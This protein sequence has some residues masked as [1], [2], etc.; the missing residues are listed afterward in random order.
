[1]PAASLTN[2]DSDFGSTPTLF[3]ATING[4][5]RSMLGVSNKNGL[6]YAFDRTNLSAG[7]LWSVQ[8]AASGESPDGG[9]GTISP[10]AWDGTSLYVAGTKTTINGST[11]TGSVSALDPAT[12]NF[13][14]QDCLNTG[15]VLGAVM[16]SPTLVTVATN[17]TMYVLAAS[18]GAV[19]FQYTDPS[20]S[21][22]FWGP[23]TVANGMVFAGNA[24][25]TL[26]AFHLP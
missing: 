10:S 16:A 3:T 1:V 8:I 6:Y 26:Y 2:A 19:L 22:F 24:D 21:T 15:A 5:T 17:K 7:P 20:S 25:G 18:S 14:W 23:P 11:C 13:E 9:Q 12:G 4:T